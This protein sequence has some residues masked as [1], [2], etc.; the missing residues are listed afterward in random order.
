MKNKILI[1]SL[2]AFLI[3]GGAMAAGASKYD[4]RT[5]DSIH[6]DD[7]Q[8]TENV[9]AK[10]LPEISAGQKVEIETEHG[11]TFFKVESDDDNSNSLMNP[12]TSGKSISMEEAARIAT[13]KVNGE[14]TEVEK[15]IEHG[16]LEYKF[17]V[18]SSQGEVDIRLDAVTGK[19]TRIEYDD[20]DDD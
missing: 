1:G 2:S 3:L 4:T 19:I 20:N 10:N 15:E 18:Q 17:E 14:I 16:R 8:K 6:S 12:S 11:Q 9:D 13:S 7:K 5:D